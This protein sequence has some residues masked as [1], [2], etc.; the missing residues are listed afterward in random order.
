MK[1]AEVHELPVRIRRD[2]GD[3]RV[4]KAVHSGQ[5]WHGQGYLV[6][7]KLAEVTCA[8]CGEKLNPLWVLTQLAYREN[9]FHE[10]H[11]RYQDELARLAERERTKCQHCGNMT[12]ISRA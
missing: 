8:A 2:A 5:C 11:E 4:L 9:R 1:D 3:E 6:D 10:L 7:D 12:R